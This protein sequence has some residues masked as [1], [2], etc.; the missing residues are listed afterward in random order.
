MEEKGFDREHMVDCAFVTIK[1]LEA[2][3]DNG[4]R[5]DSDAFASVVKVLKA[6]QYEILPPLKQGAMRKVG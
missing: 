6:E 2:Y 4:I 3:L 1:E 5:L